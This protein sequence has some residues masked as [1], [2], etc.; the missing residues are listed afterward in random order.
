MQF[1]HHEH[2]RGFA[3]NTV[4]RSGLHN[5]KRRL[6]IENIQRRATKLVTG[7]AGASCEKSLGLSSLEARRPK[8]DITALL[9]LPEQGRQRGTML[10]C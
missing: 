1:S 10:C 8:G 7:L 4:Y 5:M 2:W 6:R 9:Q 3:L